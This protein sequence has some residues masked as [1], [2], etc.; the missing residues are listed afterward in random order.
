MQR[1]IRA[2]L[3]R[4]RAA[5][6]GARLNNIL[7]AY[8][9]EAPSPQLAVDI[10]KGEW[11][12]RFP[13]PL[14]FVRAGTIPLFDD[15]RIR[16]AAEKLGGFQGRRVLE[17]GP[18]EGGHTYMLHQLGAAEI[19]AVE[20]NTRAYLKCLVVKNLFDLARARFLCGDFVPYL[21]QATE[22]FDVVVASGVL[23]HMRNP[24]QLLEQLARRADRLFLWTHY[25]DARIIAAR[26]DLAPHYAGQAPCEHAGFRHT[27]Y[28]RNYGTGLHLK[29]FCGGNAP[30]SQWLGRADLLAAVQHVGFRRVELGFDEPNHPN[31]PALAL[32]AARE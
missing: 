31:G 11:S 25:Y 16:W 32:A 3:G 28:R 18:L 4:A 21:A 30:Y 22:R 6:T 24:V 29:G 8:V 12:S 19:V 1:L 23:Y 2:W 7:D 13:P 27:L 15:D 9:S 17:L 26:P 10:F 20:A 14:D 5:C